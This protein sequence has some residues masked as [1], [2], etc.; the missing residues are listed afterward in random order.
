MPSLF[1]SAL[2]FL[3]IANSHQHY[4]FIN[5]FIVVALSESAHGFSRDLSILIELLFPIRSH[6]QALKVWPWMRVFQGH[7]PVSPGRPYRHHVFLLPLH[8]QGWENFSFH[9]MASLSVS[10]VSRMD[11]RPR[12]H[13]LR[14]VADCHHALP[15]RVGGRFR[16]IRCCEAGLPR[17]RSEVCRVWMEQSG[18]HHGTGR[19]GENRTPASY[20][21]GRERGT[22]MRAEREPGRQ[23][24][25]GL[26]N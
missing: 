10:Q 17:V 14:Q 5:G 16:A 25:Q 7:S 21:V 2:V 11:E 6:L 19:A 18:S 13:K 1:L 23:E 20:C 12:T 3:V 26:R 8:R 4:L 22:D 24:Q 9:S 15:G